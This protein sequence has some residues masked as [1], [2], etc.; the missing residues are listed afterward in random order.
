M[1]SVPTTSNNS[2]ADL[3]VRLERLEAIEAIRQLAFGYALAI[4]ARD[5]DALANLY[6]EDVR[7]G[8]RQGREALK[9]VFG[10]ALRQFT[11]SAHHV[12]NHLIEM[13]GPD[14]AIGLVGCRIEHEV[15]D[16]WVT[17]SLLYHDRYARRGG[18][19]LFRGRVQTRLYATAHGDPP[20]G[21]AKVRW[22]GAT[23]TAGGFYDALPSWR[24]Y[25]EGAP[26]PEWAGLGAE[27]LVSRL[28]RTR[29]LPPPPNYIFAPG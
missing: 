25:W 16:Q 2:S 6:V 12:T 19:W 20:T 22:P 27:E 9:E 13:V 28:R 7:A 15:G 8:D 17:A 23:P 4:D 26:G 21:E 10:A 11:C 1:A 18:V 3:Q 24:E 5:L 14:D 29:R